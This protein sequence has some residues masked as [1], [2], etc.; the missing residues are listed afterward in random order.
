MIPVYAVVSW[1]SFRFYRDY[2]Y[3]QVIRDCYEAFAIAAFFNL[4]CTYCAPT[5]HEQKEYFRMQKPKNW[6]L[7]L[8]WFQKCTGGDTHGILKKPGSGL[9]WFNIMWI[10][11]FQY[12]FIR[13][14]FTFI[15]LITQA[16]GRYCDSSLNPVF[17]HVWVQVFNAAGVTI[18]MY[19]I[20]QFYV[21]VKQDITEHRPVLKLAAIKL[22][23]F[24][25]FWQNVCFSS[26]LIPIH[27]RADK[28]F[29]SS[30]LLPQLDSLR[31]RKLLIWTSK[32]AS[33][34]YSSPLKW[35]PLA[36]CIYMLSLGKSRIASPIRTLF[37]L[38]APDIAEDH[39]MRAALL[40]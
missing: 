20:I 21:Q 37:P 33:P 15:A 39:T 7:P 32:S 22:V 29:S 1:L 40:A 31:L 38:R 11:I 13:V 17:S 8:N 28:T 18:A 3:F 9:T 19:C 12:C 25:S 23:I 30:S 16:T 14:F 4:M 36:S 27:F 26:I 5:L 24:F 35:L 2:I 10:G 34:L 6:V